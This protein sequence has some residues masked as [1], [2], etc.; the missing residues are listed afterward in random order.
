MPLAAILIG[1]TTISI[2]LCIALFIR[3]NSKTA[4]P[5]VLFSALPAIIALT[6]I[7]SIVLG[8]VFIR[9]LIIFNHD[10]ILLFNFALLIIG[11]CGIAALSAFYQLSN[12][13]SLLSV[14]LSI[15][16]F[17]SSMMVYLFFGAF[18]G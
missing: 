7:T 18:A 14:L 5:L 4:L 6:A 1:S 8:S 3:L 17:V 10:Y 13:D 12:I 2:L 15:F 9:E 16:S 11:S